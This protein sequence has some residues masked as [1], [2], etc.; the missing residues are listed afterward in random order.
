M[1]IVLGV[2]GD[3]AECL[4]PKIKPLFSNQVIESLI[5]TMR[6]TNNQEYKEIADWAY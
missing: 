1:K 2:I 4:G 3:F 5:L 6:A